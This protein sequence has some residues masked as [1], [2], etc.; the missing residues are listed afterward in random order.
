[1]YKA[2]R[3][4]GILVASDAEGAPFLLV[5]A[6]DQ[7]DLPRQIRASGLGVSV[8][9]LMRVKDEVDPV[10]IGRVVGR[11]IEGLSVGAPRLGTACENRNFAHTQ[12]GK[13]EAGC[14]GHL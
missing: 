13:V 7:I 9:A 2:T 8:V 4:R 6:A 14:C 3:P 1:I 11:C 5:Q 12:L 10:L